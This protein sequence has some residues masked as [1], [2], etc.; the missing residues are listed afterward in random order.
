MTEIE[1]IEVTWRIR[2]ACLITAFVSVLVTAL[3]FIP[4]I[5]I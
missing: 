3:L 2:K 1:K 5:L 4:L